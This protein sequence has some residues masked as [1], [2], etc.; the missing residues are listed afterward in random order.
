MGVVYLA[1]DP[2]LNRDVALKIVR[3]RPDAPLAPRRAEARLRR[4]AYAMARLRH[5]GV[6]AIH[7]V[8]V[9]DDRL[10]LAMEHIDG[11]PLGRWLEEAPRRWS[12]I[13]RVF[14][15]A[16]RGLHAAH[17][18]GVTH[19]DVKLDNVLIARDG[20][21]CVADFG[22]AH[23]TSLDEDPIAPT[24]VAGA[25]L[26][27]TPGDALLGTPAYMA[28]EQLL[29]ARG[30]PRSD[31]FSFC[32]ALHRALYGELPFLGD[33][34]YTYSRSVI[35]G[36]RRPP[37][38][39]VGPR[40]L[41]EVI[42]R[43]LAVEPGLRWPSMAALVRALED[44]TYARRRRRVYAGFAALATAALGVSGVLYF[45]RDA[46]RQC[47]AD[48]SRVSVWNP[49][50][51]GALYAQ[52]GDDPQIPHRL[53]SALGMLDRY[54]QRLNDHASALCASTRL[55]SMTDP[56]AR[57]RERGARLIERVI[58]RLARSDPAALTRAASWVA[59]LPTA[60]ELCDP[61]WVE[62]PTGTPTERALLE[63]RERLALGEADAALPIIKHVL[64]D[65]ESSDRRA[66]DAHFELGRAYEGRGD[67]AAASA[68]LQRAHALFLDRGDSLNAAVA[69][70]YLAY[71]ESKRSPTLARPYI[72]NAAIAL[73]RVRGS[74]VRRARA[75]NNLGLAYRRAGDVN[76]ALEQH[77]RAR[78]LQI[79][80]FGRSH[81][82]LAVTLH[83]LAL[84]HKQRYDLP[85][86][87]G[88]LQEAAEMLA[89]DDPHL[90]TILLTLSGVN[91]ELKRHP[92]AEE[93]VRRAIALRTS[94]FGARSYELIQPLLRLGTMMIEY[95]RDAEALELF[96]RALE[97]A[98][99]LSP[100]DV[101]TRHRL[102]FSIGV[103]H[104]ERGAHASACAR[105]QR[106][107][108]LQDAPAVNADDRHVDAT[109]AAQVRK[110]LVRCRANATR[111]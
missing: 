64:K 32:V 47:L 39:R 9:V 72:D 6:V 104:D 101:E 10:F 44:V 79:E 50:A 89:A 58:E 76:K 77:E 71:V 33:E 38:R 66:A 20:R 83:N 107:E 5:P 48:A 49:R 96:T 11:V 37:G 62:P 55:L 25:A 90:A 84:V 97:L 21:V 35:A 91:F 86:A 81:R 17:E 82:E 29:G 46:S 59:D 78:E 22:L 103:A 13:V 100:E 110:R 14:L 105:Y 95:E 67:L 75:H 40:R 2:N 51:E 16:G 4:E 7:E 74:P 106:A 19:H 42:G 63:A 43:G 18:A 24:P 61:G 36:R 65:M 23:L 26:H 53:G 108:A 69:V 70:A 27:E 31:Q 45:E 1:R 34:V 73:D 54:Q 102:E 92:E 8:G 30:D 85:K 87:L 57:C 12:A 111:G 99:A 28:P 109:V 3:P 15:D 52:L 68:A 56:A 98:E 93:Q 94:I 41:R 88:V 60:E 80:A